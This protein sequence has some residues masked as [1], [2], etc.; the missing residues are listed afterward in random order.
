MSHRP[1]T[2]V[3]VPSFFMP[4]F[5]LMRDPGLRVNA[6]RCSSLVMQSFTG[7]PVALLRSTAWDWTCQDMNFDP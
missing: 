1:D 7:F 6:A 3:T 5:A 4:T 2:A